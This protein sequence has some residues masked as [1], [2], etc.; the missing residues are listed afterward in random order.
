[1][2]GAVVTVS[3]N[4]VY[5]VNV[6]ED[7]GDLVLTVLRSQG[8]VGQVSVIALVAE[9]GA[10]NGQDFASEDLVVRQKLIV[11]TCTCTYISVANVH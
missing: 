11:L 10:T 1:M 3:Y 5:R 7:E 4:S 6:S 8:L 9:Q 2:N